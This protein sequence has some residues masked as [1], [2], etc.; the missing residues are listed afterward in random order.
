M[1]TQTVYIQPE[2]TSSAMPETKLQ[3]LLFSVLMVV[4]MVYCMTVYNL[5][6]E[7]GLALTTFWDALRLMWIEVVMAF[8]VQRYVA[9]KVAN[10]LLHLLIDVRTARPTL[11]S[12]FV[13]AGN[14]IVMAPCMTLLVNILH[15]GVS[16]Q[17]ITYWLPK[18]VVNFPFAL[19]IQIFYVGPF[20]RFVYRLLMRMTIKRKPF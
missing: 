9:K 13:A 15:N 8:F 20:V 12:V 14:V 17:L 10:M 1:K 11:I 5:A 19:C 4:C 18:L 6:L 2:K 7:D 3:D 16:P